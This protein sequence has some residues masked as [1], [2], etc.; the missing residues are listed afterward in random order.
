LERFVVLE[1]ERRRQAVTQAARSGLEHAEPLEPG[2]A[3]MPYGPD[4]ATACVEVAA[5]VGSP[6]VEYAAVRRGTA[7]MDGVH[8]GTIEVQGADRV[9][10][11]QRMLTQDM[12]GLEPGGV[13]ESFWL[14]R[15]GR[16]QADLLL[17]EFGD[18]MLVDVDR[19]AAQ[20]TVQELQGFLFSEDV[21]LAEATASWGR[22]A[23]HGAAA[24]GRLAA[25]GVDP[26]ALSTDLRCMRATVSG[27]E[28]RLVRRD[29]CGVP[30]V[31]LFV[32]SAD[33][34]RVFDALLDAGE[35]TVVRPLGWHAFNVARIE[36]GTPLFLVDFGREALPHETGLLAR[37]V[38]FRK[39]CY[40]GQE[41]V[42]RMESLG[43]PK[44]RLVG[45]RMQD[46]RLPVA[47][48]EVHQATGE[49]DVVGAI[50]SSAPAPMLGSASVAFA[51]VR[52]AMGE[53]GTRLR[54]AA[55]GDWSEAEVQ[56]GLRFLPGAA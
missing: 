14:N 48:A 7:V 9:A 40:L 31:E 52:Y 24:I 54:V 36:A 16:V 51:M 4:A 46:E 25:C 32:P 3:W 33:L 17:A 20:T 23:V 27:A 29:Q 45:L 10:F 43:K 39:G 53:P 12:K 38:N 41:V 49:G 47:G 5:E 11:L 50:T 34:E 37:R 22:L 35:D 1:N 19:F 44:R 15:K 42:A 21:S 6:A 18:R 26:S 28:I 13:R 55:E 2:V 8:R 56:A 30:G